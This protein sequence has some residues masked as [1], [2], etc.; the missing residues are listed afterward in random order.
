MKV[1]E[2]FESSVSLETLRDKTILLTGASGFV[3]KVVLEKLL[4]GIGGNGRIL[5]LMRGNRRFPSAEDRLYH[6]VLQ[7]SLFD[8]LRAEQGDVFLDNCLKKLHCLEGHLTQPRFGLDQDTFAATAF[9]LDLIINAAASVDFREPLDD[10]LNTNTLALDSLIDFSKFT[11]HC[12]LIHVSTCYV[13][14]H[15]TGFCSE[16]NVVA[17]RGKLPLT[18]TGYVDTDAV[19]ATLQSRISVIYASISGIEERQTALVDLGLEIANTFGWNDTYTFTK[20]LGEQRL[21]N[22]LQGRALTVLRPSIIE[23]VLKD[24]TP[25][26]IE[27][28]K[29]ADAV[30]MAYAREHV[31]LFPGRPS[32]AIDIIPVDYV[33]N[34][35][36]ISAAEALTAPCQHRFY[37]CGSSAENPVTMKTL[38]RLVRKAATTPGSGLDRLFPRQPQKAFVMVPAPVFK[39]ITGGGLN[40]QR[41]SYR[42]RKSLGLSTSKRTLMKMETTVRLAVVFAFYTTQRYTFDNSE[43]LSLAAR[44]SAADRAA[45]PVS[46]ADIDWT[47]YLGHIHLS[48]LND[49]ALKPR[50]KKVK[51]PVAADA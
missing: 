32:A 24:P 11:P 21:L 50:S 10:A 42:L 13:H 31:M 4:R 44:L 41:W 46:T 18:S 51:T 38:I 30:I 34:S 17:L 15:H 36:L 29:V 49:Y 9:S 28:V 33:A 40:Y 20:W 12:P 47:H 35:I 25:G 22:A 43:L 16:A 6:E 45:F 8:K 7:S 2:A 1:P 19:V 3:G 23:S 26:W 39:L 48:G 27:G 14:G 5:L 37:Q